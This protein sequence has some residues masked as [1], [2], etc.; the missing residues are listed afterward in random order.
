MKL[1][2]LKKKERQKQ[3]PCSLE[4]TVVSN[5]GNRFLSPYQS[6]Q[7]GLRAACSGNNLV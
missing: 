5:S 3:K 2:I 6:K 7:V 4:V 1:T